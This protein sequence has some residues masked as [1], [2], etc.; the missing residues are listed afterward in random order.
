MAPI[1]L[2]PLKL[3]PDMLWPRVADAARHALAVGALQPIETRTAT[4][5]DAG[6]EFIVRQVSS[7]RRKPV[8]VES[9]TGP[10][11]LVPCDPDL[12][13][14]DVSDTHFALLNKYNV[15]EH[16]LLIVTRQFEDQRAWLN[17]RD[18][19]AMWACLAGRE[20]LGFY[21]GG[22]IAGASQPHK[23]LQVVPLPLA[24]EGPAVPMDA[25]VTRAAPG[26]GVGRVP[27]LP[28]AHACARVPRRWWENA[29][30]GALGAWRCYALMLRALGLG[31]GPLREGEWQSAPYNLVITREWMLLVPRCKE[32]I[33]GITVNALGFAGALLVR[34]ETEMDALRVRRPMSVLQAV[35]CREDGAHV[36]VGG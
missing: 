21:N 14:T 29:E 9:R 24:A 31:A 18:F 15:L 5:T 32:T 33:A 11:P 17:A 3:E 6:V 8:S 16:H 2:S 1:R 7:L 4:M 28:F 36:P 34:S 27:E 22:R 30:T 10:P 23:H 26:R 35:A 12:F 13:V 20:A 19:Q 25:L